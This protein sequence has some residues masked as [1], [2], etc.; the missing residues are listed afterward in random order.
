MDAGRGRRRS[1]SRNQW[2]GAL[3]VPIVRNKLHFFGTYERTDEHAY[4]TVS[5]LPQFYSALQRRAIAAGSRRTSEMFR[6]RLPGDAE[7]ERHVPLPERAHALLLQRL[8]RR[9]VELQR[10]ATNSFPRYTSAGTHTWVLN[11]HMVERGELAAGRARR[12]RRRMS[13]DFTP[14]TCNAQRR[15]CLAATRS[16]ARAYTFPS[17]FQWGYARVSPSVSC[18]TPGTTT[19]FKDI[20]E[21]LSISAGSHNYKLGGAYSNYKTHEDA[22][23]NPLGTWTF[24]VDQYFN[25]S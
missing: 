12:I 23:P 11:S 19:P 15:P 2:G 1:Y 20:Y 10:R 13:K 24:G 22:A 25:P 8:R 18:R 5:A 16:A 17:G 21:A 9:G 14:A 4:F 6:A 3:G 7:P